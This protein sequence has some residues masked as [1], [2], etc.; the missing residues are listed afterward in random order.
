LHSVLSFNKEKYHRRQE[1][2]TVTKLTYNNLLDWTVIQ[3]ETCDLKCERMPWH[4]VWGFFSSSVLNGRHMPKVANYA[5]RSVL[6]CHYMLVFLMSNDIIF[7]PCRPHSSTMCSA[8]E[9]RF[10]PKSHADQVANN[11]LAN[12]T[13]GN[14][15]EAHRGPREVINHTD[16]QTDAFLVW[17]DHKWHQTICSPACSSVC[18]FCSH[19][20]NKGRCPLSALSP[21]KSLGHHYPSALACR[22]YMTVFVHSCRQ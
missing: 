22:K 6:F 18:T 1:R 16:K 17:Y 8:A 2:K 20:G 11:A 14:S 15:E 10:G 9:W 12:Q 19:L 21:I 3:Y 13:K 4:V 5:L 7:K